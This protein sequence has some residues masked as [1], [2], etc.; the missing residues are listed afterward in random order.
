[1]ANADLALY[2]A[3]ANGG[4]YQFFIPAF[5]AQARARI[6]LDLELRRAFAREEF[7][8]YFQPQ[9]RLADNTV[10]GAEALLRW[11]H[12]VRGIVAPGAFIETLAKSVIAPELGRW[13][14]KTACQKAAAWRAMGLPLARIA[15]NLFPPTVNDETLVRETEDVLRQTG[16]PAKALEL[17]IT[18]NVAL[19]YDDAAGPLNKLYQRGVNLAFDDFG[20]GYASLSSLTR[21]PVS[22]IKIDRSFVAK[23]TDDAKDAAI[24]RSLIAM[25]HKLEL[26]VIAEGVETEAQV[27]FLVNERCE[28]AQGFLYAKPLPAAEF[29]AYL[30][31]SRPVLQSDTLAGGDA[32][33]SVKRGVIG[34]TRRRKVSK[35]LLEGS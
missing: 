10:V 17:E 18:E 8:L 29:E 27:A 15:V 23:V 7:E 11:R 12:P 21:F 16:L 22:R 31:A 13:I 9:V 6:E 5:R 20:I 33:L 26:E 35:A 30:K 34:T 1:M 14:L 28:E 19:N 32:G 4:C 25:A 2:R 24:V 3:K